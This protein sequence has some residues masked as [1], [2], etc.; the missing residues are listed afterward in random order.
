MGGTS[1]FPSPRV[2]VVIPTRNRARFLERTLACLAPQS[3]PKRSYEVIVVN[4]GST[5]DTRDVVKSFAREGNFRVLNIAV[6]NAG[7]ARNMGAAQARGK[8][9]LFMDDECLVEP[10][11]LKQ[12]WQ[13]HQDA[14][15]PAVARGPTSPV[16]SFWG[17]SSFQNLRASGKAPRAKTGGWLLSVDELKGGAFKPLFTVAGRKHFYREAID[18]FG[19]DLKDCVAPWPLFLTRNVSLPKTLWNQAGGFDESLPR[20]GLEDMEMGFRLHRLGA[21]FLL[22]PQAACYWQVCSVDKRRKAR[23]LAHHY[24][25]ICRKHRDIGVFLVWRLLT[26][27]MSF[28]AFN[29]A[30]VW[31]RRLERRD[32]SA[33]RRRLGVAERLAARYGQDPEFLLKNL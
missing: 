14:G 29:R 32:L 8:V 7:K 6:S 22:A 3:L 23:A 17:A 20:V 25:L 2:S 10:S 18:A 9:I 26:G 11:F 21:P 13:A 27:R 30:V 16:L 28:R 19:T 15:R 1:P 33:A 5:D 24:R 12:H 4:D 31:F